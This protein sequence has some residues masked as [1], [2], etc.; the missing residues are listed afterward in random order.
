LNIFCFTHCRKFLIRLFFV[1]LKNRQGNACIDNKSFTNAANIF[2]RALDIVGGFDDKIFLLRRSECFMALQL[3][4]CCARDS[5]AY[6]N[7]CE[8]NNDDANCEKCN[9]YYFYVNVIILSIFIYVLILHNKGYHRHSVALKNLG[10][11]DQAIK[12]LNLGLQFFPDS[13][14]LNGFRVNMFRKKTT[15]QAKLLKTTHKL[16]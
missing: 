10:L 12:Q 6:I 16:K 3:W 5:E 11:Y 7:L 9:I 2:S 1:F 14:D 15:L 8:L 13:A 4:E